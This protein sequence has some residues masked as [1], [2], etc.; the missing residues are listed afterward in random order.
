M[1]QGFFDGLGW[2]QWTGRT[3]LIAAE[4]MKASLFPHLPGAFPVFY[5]SYEM[6]PFRASFF[7]SSLTGLGWL[8]DSTPAINCR[9]IVCRPSGTCRLRKREGFP[10]HPL[11]PGLGSNFGRLD[12]GSTLHVPVRK[13]PEATE[14][15]CFIDTRGTC[16]SARNDDRRDNS[17]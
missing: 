10:P 8:D 1:A 14:S 9:A 4:T 11:I 13:F 6:P 2:I 7:L 15:G 16:R 5:K 17:P 3:V 12:S